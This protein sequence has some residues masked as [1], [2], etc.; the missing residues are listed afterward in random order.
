MA[1]GS[2]PTLG[3]RKMKELKVLEL[4]DKGH[5]YRKIA[6]EVHLSLREV[7]QYIHSISNKRKSPSVT[8]SHDEII[9]EYKVNTLRS[10]VKELESQKEKL[11]NEVT[12]LRGQIYN[13][14]Y[15]LRAK[16]SELDVVKRNLEY[17]RFSKEI[18]RLR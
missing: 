8:S 3:K 10:E 18:L 13:I 7:S 14:Q 12:D 5:S 1:V 17:E 15:K 11:K 6:K 9:L 16:Q 4:Y 2:R